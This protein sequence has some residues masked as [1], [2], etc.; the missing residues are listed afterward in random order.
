[1]K[2]CPR[3]ERRKFIMMPDVRKPQA[4][5]PKSE[6]RPP[7]DWITS[8]DIIYLVWSNIEPRILGFFA[9][10]REDRVAADRRDAVM[11]RLDML[12]K[13]V[14]KLTVALNHHRL[15]TCEVVFNIPGIAQLLDPQ[16]EKFDPEDM[17]RILAGGVLDY[18][19]DRDMRDRE[20][21]RRVITKELGL[22]ASA[23]P[24]ALVAATYLRCGCCSRQFTLD[25]AL[26]HR[27]RGLILA[28][29]CEG[30]SSETL[31]YFTAWFLRGNMREISWTPEWDQYGPGIRR[32]AEVIDMFGLDPKTA[33]AD[34]MDAT[35]GTM[36][37][38]DSHKDSY[39]PFAY[40][41]IMDWRAAVSLLMTTLLVKLLTFTVQLY[42]RHHFLTMRKATEAEISVAITLE[43]TLERE[44]EKKPA[45]YRCLLCDT[46]RRESKEVVS[47][48]LLNM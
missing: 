43:A 2:R 11:K 39:L 20:A 23:D 46:S 26:Q 3:A 14:R 9:Q 36:R 29:P 5:T 35:C 44:R 17:K 4:L 45:S 41:A 27:C 38:S 1:M 22:E 7:T 33:T 6:L 12:D 30:M 21:L 37:M 8:L 32:A 28:E 19:H 42:N 25:E 24:F 18:V 10:I 34:D 40:A 48:H 13:L 47:R 16:L 31:K 15:Y